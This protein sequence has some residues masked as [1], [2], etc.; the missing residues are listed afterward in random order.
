MK[1]Q[2]NVEDPVLLQLDRILAT[3]EFVRSER[4]SRF[5]RYVVLQK[6]AGKS[7]QLKET[8]IGTE[9][10]GRKPDYDPRSDPVVRMEAAKL[11]SRLHNYYATVGIN[12]P[13]R[14][15]I[16]KGAYVP[17][18]QSR[19]VTRRTKNWRILAALR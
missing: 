7:D 17:Q 10:F 3:P 8:V 13:I 5:L 4:Q 16:P 12:D 6:L 15:E 14:I 11:R 19:A 18:W 9:V 2:A 1:L